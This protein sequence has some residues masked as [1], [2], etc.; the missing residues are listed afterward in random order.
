M[1]FDEINLPLRVGY[2][3]SGGPSFMT[4]VVTVNGGYEQRNQNW[5]QARRKY[6]ARTGVRSAQDAAILVSFFQARAGRARGFRLRD[7]SD[8]TSSADGM[9]NATAFDQ[10]IGVSDGVQKDFQLLKI[11]GDDQ[12]FYGREI[13]KPVLDSVLISVDDVAY[14]S[15]WNVDTT[16]GVVS[17]DQAPANGAVIKAGFSF[18]VPV[19]FDTDSLNLTATH[20]KLSNNET[21]IPLVEVHV[22]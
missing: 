13:K 21:D 4:S 2:G 15:E 18:D 17:F 5:S 9:A 7:W 12:S 19:R 22:S 6:D 10:L 1:A 3:A 20:P 8:F 14:V 11:Y 16:T